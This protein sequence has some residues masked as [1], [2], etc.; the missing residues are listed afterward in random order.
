MVQNNQEWEQMTEEIKSLIKFKK[1]VFVHLS[2][3]RQNFAKVFEENEINFS[4]SVAWNSL[5][6]EWVSKQKQKQWKFWFSFACGALPTM[7]KVGK[8]WWNKIKIFKNEDIQST[9][10]FVTKVVILTGF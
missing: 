3:I 4:W 1:T 5:K 7:T 6:Q 8:T 9:A 2:K 10:L